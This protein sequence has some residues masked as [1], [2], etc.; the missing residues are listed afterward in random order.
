MHT[1]LSDLIGVIR[2]GNGNLLLSF[3]MIGESH[4]DT[5]AHG[6]DWNFV[7]VTKQNCSV[8]FVPEGATE[9]QPERIDQ[10]GPAIKIHRVIRRDVFHAVD[11]DRRSAFR[12]R[13]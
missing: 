13:C 2:G 10:R 6:F 9:H 4:C 1:D 3:E 8:S 5:F 11:A 12:Y 7:I